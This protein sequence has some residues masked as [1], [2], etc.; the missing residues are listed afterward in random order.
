MKIIKNIFISTFSFFLL[1]LLVVSCNVNPNNETKTFEYDVDFIDYPSYNLKI[2]SNELI[3][4]PD[5]PVKEGFK[6]VGWYSEGVKFDFNTKINSNVTMEARFVD[7]KPLI[8]QIKI[9]EKKI[10][11]ENFEST[12]TKD[13]ISKLKE[14]LEKAK[15]ALHDLSLEEEMYSLISELRS[16]IKDLVHISGDNEKADKKALKE[17]IKLAREK[18]SEKD[19]ETKYTK[20]SRR[21]LE[22]KLSIAVKLVQSVYA[23]QDSVDNCV[24]ELKKAI[25][26][27]VLIDS[28]NINDEVHYY[29]ITLNE[30]VKNADATILFNKLDTAG[31]K[32]VKGSDV[33][34]EY[35]KYI[36]LNGKDIEDDFGIEMEK[37]ILRLYI[38]KA[39]IADELEISKDIPYK[40]IKNDKVLNIGKAS[41]TLILVFNGTKFINPSTSITKAKSLNLSKT[42]ILVKDNKEQLISYG[43][44]PE[45]SKGELSFILDEKELV[46][47]K[48]KDI[49]NTISITY[50]GLIESNK[51]VNIDVYIKNTDVYKTILVRVI[52]E[53]GEDVTP[54]TPTPDE[55][56]YLLN[57]FIIN[58]NVDLTNSYN[59]GT[60][61]LF[62]DTL[63]Q[64]QVRN[65]FSNVSLQGNDIV[66]SGNNNKHN[67]NSEYENFISFD[68]KNNNFLIEKISLNLGL[69]NKKDI[70]NL[71]LVKIVFIKGDIKLEKTI[72]SKDFE[73]NSNYKD[74]EIIL[75]EK[76]RDSYDEI[77]ITVVK[78]NKL[79]ENK[80]RIKISNLKVYKVHNK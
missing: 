24:I 3:K 54:P 11:E 49:N 19:F 66:I 17:Q 4:A 34:Q 37:G 60:S 44:S 79:K 70:K 58:K 7:V 57:N 48:I 51:E 40:A 55:D 23:K 77:L 8:E 26:D 52:K 73:Q 56:E 65:K 41:N 38:K 14:T 32:S 29:D 21:E 67:N 10:N 43:F 42:E 75:D 22:Q 76:E 78:K 62:T 27:L 69:F 15:I 6:F 71:D 63:K 13:S 47:F 35:R 72:L 1:S 25:D 68:L 2:K 36:K 61:L 46:N 45:N 12:Y 74:F 33:K 28:E 53:D 9:T 50:I 18:K 80:P 16:N 31:F 64:E 39:S 20:T 59:D 5:A 30:T